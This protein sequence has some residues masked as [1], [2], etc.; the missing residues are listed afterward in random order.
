MT[1]RTCTS[2]RTVEISC[3][4]IKRSV[5][6]AEIDSMACSLRSDVISERLRVGIRMGRATYL[7]TEETLLDRLDSPAFSLPDTNAALSPAGSLPQSG[8]ACG[9]TEDGEAQVGAITCE[10]SRIANPGAPF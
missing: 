6:L 7:V 3:I 5:T 8:A 2:N 1:P 9:G 4:A 10:S